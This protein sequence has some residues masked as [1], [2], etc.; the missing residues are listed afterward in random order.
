MIVRIV[1]SIISSKVVGIAIEMPKAVI[2]VVAGELVV[3]ERI[4]EAT[5]KEF[6]EDGFFRSA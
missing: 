1:V 2:L 5:A 3:R 6:T 4:Q